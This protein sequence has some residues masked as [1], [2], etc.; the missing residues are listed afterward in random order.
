MRVT[1]D[2]E[3]VLRPLDL[4]IPMMINGCMNYLAEEILQLL[5]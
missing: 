3:P 4:G 5:V 2:D 1:T